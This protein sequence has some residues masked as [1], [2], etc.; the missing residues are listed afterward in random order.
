MRESASIQQCVAAGCL[1]TTP[2]KPEQV[3]D[4]KA[5]NELKVQVQLPGVNNPT[6]IPL[7][8]KGFKGAFESLK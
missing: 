6:N 3:N 8:L 2:L 7:S 1:A 4:L 5:G